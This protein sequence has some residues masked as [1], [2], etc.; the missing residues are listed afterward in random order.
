MHRSAHIRRARLLTKVRNHALCV[1]FDVSKTYNSVFFAHL[2]MHTFPIRPFPNL[3]IPPA[4]FQHD[5]ATQSDHYRKLK[6]SQ[7]PPSWRMEINARTANHFPISL[8]AIATQNRLPHVKHGPCC[9]IASNR[10]SC[11]GRR[12]AG[13][14]GRPGGPPA[15]ER[16]DLVDFCDYKTSP[17]LQDF[18]QITRVLGLN[19][20]HKAPTRR[21]VKIKVAEGHL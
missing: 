21:L 17:R 3:N 16:K 18:Q 8:F 20:V 15:G 10:I 6:K 13:P 1:F 7:K 4:P 2:W 11:R 14:P 5:L 9:K 12:A 19:I